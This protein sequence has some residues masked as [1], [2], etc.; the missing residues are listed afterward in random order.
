MSLEFGH[1]AC[2]FGLSLSETVMS[3]VKGE[4]LFSNFHQ[5]IFTY[6]VLQMSPKWARVF[7][8]Q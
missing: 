6:L 5:L 8:V 2:A 4:A 1:F 7:L 3:I